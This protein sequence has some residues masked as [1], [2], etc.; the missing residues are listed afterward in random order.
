MGEGEDWGDGPGDMALAG[1]A[2]GAE[3]D[4]RT[5]F[6]KPSTVLCTCHPST[7][8]MEKGVFLRLA[9]QPV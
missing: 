4:L 2:Q 5:R 1:K 6:K 3:F 7:R 9:G 8:E